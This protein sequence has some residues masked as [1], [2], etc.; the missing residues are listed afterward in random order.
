MHDRQRCGSQAYTYCQ[1]YI[2]TRVGNSIVWGLPRQRSS[3]SMHAQPLS[4]QVVM[5]STLNTYTRACARSLQ[6]L[7]L[8]DWH[9]RPG[10][11]FACTCS[12]MYSVQR[13]AQRSRINLFPFSFFSTDWR[14][15]WWRTSNSAVTAFIAKRPR[16][17]YSCSYVLLL[18]L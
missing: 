17:A 2:R 15:Q 7:H 9:F 13:W 3:S 14:W 11:H 12:S 6:K 10:L 1:E 5:H 16:V 18:L 4:F 8:F